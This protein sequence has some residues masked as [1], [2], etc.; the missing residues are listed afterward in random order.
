MKAKYRWKR[1]GPFD[2]YVLKRKPFK[3]HISAWLRGCENSNWGWQWGIDYQTFNRRP[4]IWVATNNF[5]LLG[6]ERWPRR[7]DP[8]ARGFEIW[9]MGFWWIK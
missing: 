3:G 4:N 7:S 5:V 1:F 9:F 2:Y 8:A 6:Y